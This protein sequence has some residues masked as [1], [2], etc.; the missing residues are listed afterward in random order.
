M[1]WYDVSAVIIKLAMDQQ[2]NID[3][4]NDQLKDLEAQYQL[5]QPHTELTKVCE[6]RY[7]MKQLMEKLRNCKRSGRTNFDA[8]W[9]QVDTGYP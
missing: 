3:L 6:L 4:M 1:R 8:S 5:L 2:E 7:K 9:E